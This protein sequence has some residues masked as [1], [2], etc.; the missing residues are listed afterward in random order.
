MYGEVIDQIGRER[1][2][3]LEENRRLIEEN[4]LLLRASNI[5][6]LLKSVL[7]LGRL[8]YLC[9]VIVRKLYNG[10]RGLMLRG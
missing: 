1:N 9:R 7:G 2:R 6:I 3:L 10:W 4:R 8:T 5:V